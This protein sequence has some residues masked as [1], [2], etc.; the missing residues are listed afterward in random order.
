[1]IISH[2]WFSWCHAIIWTNNGPLNCRI[3]ASPNFNVKNKM[4]GILRMAPR[5]AENFSTPNNWLHKING[6]IPKKDV[7]ITSSWCYWIISRFF[8]TRMFISLSHV[9]QRLQ[10][11]TRIRDLNLSFIMFILLRMQVLFHERRPISQN[12]P[13]VEASKYQF[14]CFKT[15][16]NEIFKAKQNTSFDQNYY[17][18]LLT[19][20]IIMLLL[21]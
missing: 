9:V 17:M 6:K 2:N 20:T 18:S 1:M 8:Y 5:S 12:L 13:S 16:Q 10:H 7:F 3:Y 14:A 15:D 21:H 4:L 19:V 11:G